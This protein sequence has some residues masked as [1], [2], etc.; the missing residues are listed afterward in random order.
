LFAEY[1]TLRGR[2]EALREQKTEQ[3]ADSLAR[4]WDVSLEDAL[5]IA[6]ALRDVGFFEE[7]TSRGEVT[8]WVPFVYRPYLSMSQGKVEG[9]QG[10][11][12]LDDE[13]DDDQEPAAA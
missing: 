3:S 2:I 6:R 9:L 4:L 7:R 10:P 1:P 5:V 12:G 11:D 13:E 8:F